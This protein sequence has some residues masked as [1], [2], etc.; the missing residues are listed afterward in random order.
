MLNISQIIVFNFCVVMC[1]F[2]SQTHPNTDI[3]VYTHQAVNIYYYKYS[4]DGMNVIAVSI[5]HHHVTME[6]REFWKLRKNG[7]LES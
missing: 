2:Q 4:V 3:I 1:L 5:L 6:I 7:H